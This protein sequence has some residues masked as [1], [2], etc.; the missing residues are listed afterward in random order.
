MQQTLKKAKQHILNTQT[1][2]QPTRILGL[3]LYMATINNFAI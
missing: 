3:T 2:C 1:K